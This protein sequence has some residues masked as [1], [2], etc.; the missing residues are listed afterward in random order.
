ML[1]CARAD[2][3]FYCISTENPLD[4][5]YGDLNSYKECEDLCVCAVQEVFCL[6]REVSGGL[7]TLYTLESTSLEYAETCDEKECI[8][9]I[10]S[11]LWASASS[12][13][14]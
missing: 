9:N 10:D 12:E 11:E 4:K 1:R 6:V 14:T 3:A 5:F 7:E 13:A 2:H 8:C